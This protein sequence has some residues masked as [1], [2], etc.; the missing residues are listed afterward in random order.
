MSVR[1]ASRLVILENDQKVTEARAGGLL[2]AGGPL[3]YSL[4]AI[5]FFTCEFNLAAVIGVALGFNSTRTTVLGWALTA[6]SCMIAMSGLILAQRIAYIDRDRRALEISSVITIGTALIPLLAGLSMPAVVM[7]PISAMF[8][9][10]GA[11]GMRARRDL[12]DPARRD[13]STA[14]RSDPSPGSTAAPTAESPQA[15]PKRRRR[16]RRRRRTGRQGS[17]PQEG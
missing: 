6:A 1:P 17:P 4:I 8:V 7:W 15:R 14:V 10:V 11:S 12:P 2:N 16:R 9:L 13:E 3:W 5:S